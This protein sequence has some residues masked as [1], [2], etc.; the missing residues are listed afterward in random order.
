M[1]LAKRISVLDKIYAIYDDFVAKL[2]L[3]CKEKCTYCCTTHVTLT[4]LEG[5]RIISRRTSNHKADLIQKVKLNLTQQRFQ[6]K[7]TTNHLATLCAEGIEP[8]Y[9]TSEPEGKKCSLLA[10]SLCAI[11]KWR[12]FGCRCLVSRYNCR[13]KGYA[14]IDD[15]V[16]SVN[17]VFLQTIEHVDV[18]GCTGNLMDVLNVMSSEHNQTA[19]ENNALN[20]QNAGLIS[21]H[22]LKV[23]MIP[24]EHRP[25][26][27]PILQALRQIKL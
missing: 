1:E 18:N 19:Y 4:T 23:L 2:D 12:P 13:E 27:E 14:E 15:F 21:N 16:L 3:A 25:R 9:E 6:P 26:M 22:P 8:P 5:Y 17:T 24:P 10:D 11:Y 7:I 20:C